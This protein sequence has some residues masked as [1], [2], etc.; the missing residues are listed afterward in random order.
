MNLCST[1]QLEGQVVC[2]IQ[3]SRGQAVLRLP[4]VWITLSLACSSLPVRVPVGEGDAVTADMDKAGPHHPCLPGLCTHWLG[5][6]RRKAGH[7]P[8]VKPRKETSW[9]PHLGTW[10]SWQWQE[11]VSKDLPR[12]S[13]AGSSPHAFCNVIG[14]RGEQWMPTA[15]ALARLL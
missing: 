15:F 4:G 9:N 11:T 13:W 8:E 2:A 12:T 10:R 7:Q 6:R 5:W 1:V 3:H 14:K